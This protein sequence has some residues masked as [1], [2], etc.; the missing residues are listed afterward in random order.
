MKYSNY[1]TEFLWKEENQD[2]QASIGRD[3]VYNER[4]QRRSGADYFGIVDMSGKR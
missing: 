1:V 3:I 2:D 4:P